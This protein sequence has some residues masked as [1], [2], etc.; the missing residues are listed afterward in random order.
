MSKLTIVYIAGI[1][2]NDRRQP[3]LKFRTLLSVERHN[4]FLQTS[5]CFV[6]TL[7]SVLI[8]ALRYSTTL[9]SKHIF[10][11]LYIIIFESNF[12]ALCSCK[13]KPR[14]QQSNTSYNT[15]G[16]N[17]LLLSIKYTWNDGTMEKD[18]GFHVI[19][20]HITHIIFMI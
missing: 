9:S 1:H 16:K 3:I 4:I 20:S 12:S 7:P 18:I 8:K 17:V 19:Y 5:H 11:F 13:G 2:N 14:A 15:V 6:I 10:P